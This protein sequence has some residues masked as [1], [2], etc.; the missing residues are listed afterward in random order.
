MTEAEEAATGSIAALEALP[1]SPLLADATGAMALLSAYRGDDEAVV[2]WGKRTVELA[3]RFG[4]TEKRVDGSIGLATVELF[5][6]GDAEPLERTLEEARANR[7]PQLA[8][9]AMHNLALGSAVRGSDDQAARWIQAGLAHCDGLELDLWRLA[10]LSRRVRLELG[11]GA[12]TDAT[13]TAEL[14]VAETRDSPEPRLQALLVL[15]LVRARRGDPGTAPLLA[16]AEAIV[17]TATDPGWHASLACAHA[18]V[19]WLERRAAEARKATEAAYER[20]RVAASSWWLG[21]LAYWRRKNGIVEDVPATVTEPWSLQLAGDW[22]AA[23]SAWE[24]RARPYEAA[25]ALAEADDEE[26]LR[27]ALA[28]LQRLGAG[29][30]ARMVARRVRERGARDVPRGPRRST[31]ANVGRLTS[32]QLDGSRSSPRAAGTPR[33]P[34]GSSSPGARSTT[35]CRRSCGSCRSARA[36]RPWRQPGASGC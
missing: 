27:A 28:E 8:A 32:R 13:A 35:T 29:P 30:A 24:A 34:N 26:A 4:D 25:R 14:I 20:E 19:A 21:E 5:R 23:A 17:A 18:E 3:R 2:A 31:A 12:W 16:E 6:A 1:E 9:H 22:R 10:L 33:S 15:A 7:L 11:R 36:A